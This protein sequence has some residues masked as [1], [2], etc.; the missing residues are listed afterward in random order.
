MPIRV[1]LADDHALLREGLRAVLEKLPELIVV[2]EAANGREATELAAGLQPDLVIIDV[3]MPELN[4]VEATRRI[5]ETSRR[6]AVIALSAQAEPRA[7]AEMLRAGASGFVIKAGPPE[8]LIRAIR[9]VREGGTYL[10]PQ[11]AASVV[12]VFI[13]S[14]RGP[15]SE[16]D[17]SPLTS[18]ERE[19]L[20]LIAEGRS[21][22][23][24]AQDLCVS[25]KTV[26]SHRR[27][28]M[29]KLGIHTVAGLT[30]YAVREGIVSLGE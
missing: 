11:V 6:T 7:V 17:P 10:S 3:G 20:Q 21:T 13:R 15:A 18:R 5:R 1:L 25:T 24:I 26:E 28:L 8:E 9:A 19:V 4:G 14:D 12:Q 2:G 23:E 27:Q 22:K 30:R 16:L 29:G